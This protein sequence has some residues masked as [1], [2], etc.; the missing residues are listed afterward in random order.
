MVGFIGLLFSFHPGL[1]SI[2]ELALIGVITTL[3]A[4][5]FFLPALAQWLEDRS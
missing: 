1:R 4:A 5:M 3:L 2:G